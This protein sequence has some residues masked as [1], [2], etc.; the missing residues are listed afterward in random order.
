M[1]LEDTMSDFT[2]EIL[3]DWNEGKF[4]NN[5]QLVT[6]EMKRLE[7]ELKSKLEHEARLGSILKSRTATLE[8]QKQGLT[9]DDVDDTEP[10][11]VPGGQAPGSA[12]KEE[13]RAPTA[14]S[15]GSAIEQRVR[16]RE[17][18]RFVAVAHME[19]APPTIA[20]ALRACAEAGARDV[21]VHPYFL[22]PGR[23]TSEDIPRVVEEAARRHPDL[24]VRV[25]EPLGLHEKLVDVVLERVEQ[26]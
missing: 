6:A 3:N 19:L 10:L 20:D 12:A 7:L 23:H 9:D 21:V 14:G 2:D 25:S 17:P 1:V 22:S 11:F 15:S 4:K 16:A 5:F 8:E 18:E 26:T 13:S 24:R